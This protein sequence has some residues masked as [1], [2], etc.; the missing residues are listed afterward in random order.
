[1][2]TKE[3]LKKHFSDNKKL[4]FRHIYRGYSEDERHSE[5]LGSMARPISEKLGSMARHV[6]R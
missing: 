2:N 6:S 1:M 3:K 4:Y 5:K